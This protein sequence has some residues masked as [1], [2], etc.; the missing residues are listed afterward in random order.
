MI[1][2]NGDI[3]HKH[4]AKNI[5]QTKYSLTFILFGKS[6]NLCKIGDKQFRVLEQKKK[7]KVG[8]KLFISNIGKIEF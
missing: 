7:L 1:L 5:S 2:V 6:R 8:K 4:N 3:K